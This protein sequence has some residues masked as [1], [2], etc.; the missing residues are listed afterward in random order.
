[1]NIKA[2][3]RRAA[4]NARNAYNNL[5]PEDQNALGA[6]AIAFSTPPVKANPYTGVRRVFAGGMNI[7]TKPVDAPA[8]FVT[9]LK[10]ETV[11]PGTPESFIVEKGRSAI[12]FVGTVAAIGFWGSGIRGTLFNSGRE[13]SELSNDGLDEITDKDPV[14][15]IPDSWADE[16]DKGTDMARDAAGRLGESI[17]EVPSGEFQPF[18]WFFKDLLFDGAENLTSMPVGVALF[19]GAVAVGAAV[20][21]N[22]RKV[23]V[24]RDEHDNIIGATGHANW[25]ARDGLG[26]K[27]LGFSPFGA[28]GIG[29]SGSGG[30]IRQ[31]R[32]SK[33]RV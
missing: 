28:L 27:A 26:Q 20:L 7:L 9:T 33:R 23:T 18:K 31:R 11:E 25:S 12:R 1:M 21:G 6:A 16:I 8:R 4:A 30:S 15:I 22:E 19:S 32:R 24:H 3:A 14:D 13:T 29:R 10:N 17:S 5:D 2:N